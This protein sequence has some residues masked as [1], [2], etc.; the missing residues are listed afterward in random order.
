MIAEVATTQKTS[1]TKI[2]G[3]PNTT[4]AALL[5]NGVPT[6][7]PRNGRTANHRISNHQHRRGPTQNRLD[8][9]QADVGVGPLWAAD[10]RPDR[11][12]SGPSEASLH[13]NS[14]TR[15]SP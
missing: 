5:K 11:F 3:N 4:G 8:C 2:T 14:E 1:Q 12:Q 6:R 9:R 7:I 15:A 13:P 10:S